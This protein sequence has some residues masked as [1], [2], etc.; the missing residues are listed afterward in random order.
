MTVQ[1]MRVGEIGT[2]AAVLGNPGDE[3][4]YLLGAYLGQIVE[5]IPTPTRGLQAADGAPNGRR[6]RGPELDRRERRWSAAS[7][8]RRPT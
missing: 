8:W 6:P 4:A 1:L 2:T 7:T 3:V 5:R